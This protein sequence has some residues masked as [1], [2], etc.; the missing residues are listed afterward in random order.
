MEFTSYSAG[1]FGWDEQVRLAHWLAAHPGPVIA[2]NQA[3]ERVLRL[4]RELGFAITLLDA[5][6]RIAANGDRRPAV[7]ILAIKREH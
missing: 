2:S 5:P 1:G 4:Y 3:T 7:E 6:R